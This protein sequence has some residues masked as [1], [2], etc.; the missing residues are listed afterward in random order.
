MLIKILQKINHTSIKPNFNFGDEEEI[1]D[2][3]EKID[4]LEI[5]AKNKISNL[6][7]PFSSWF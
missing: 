1:K 3:D 6:I 4:A 2:S 5:K 7:I